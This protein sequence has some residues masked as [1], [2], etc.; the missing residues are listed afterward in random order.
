MN[1]YNTVSK[2][3]HFIY[4]RFQPTV[5]LYAVMLILCVIAFVS[6]N[7]EMNDTVSDFS[8]ENITVNYFAKAQHCYFEANNDSAMIYL[9]KAM[10]VV[11]TN[12]YKDVTD[13]Y[14]LRSTL[15]ANLAQFEESM[16]SARKALTI[17]EEHRLFGNQT[18][19][20]LAIGKVHYL[21][22]NDEKA[23]EYMLQAKTLAEKCNC[24][25]N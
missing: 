21:M 19:A 23:E 25:K 12:N 16:E 5:I 4:R 6:C 11:D 10:E 18:L 17:C 20:L 8:E 7:K 24:I 3:L 14:I 9:N 15:F 13:I 1:K 22:Y 2:T